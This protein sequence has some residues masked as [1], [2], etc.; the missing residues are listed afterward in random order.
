MGFRMGRSSIRQMLDDTSL[1]YR[2]YAK[3][4]WFESDYFYPTQLGPLKKAAGRLFDRIT[5]TIRKMIA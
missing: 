5:P 2:Y 3:M 4:G 1:D